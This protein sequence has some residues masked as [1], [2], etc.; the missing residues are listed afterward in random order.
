MPLYTL[1]L[2]VLDEEKQRDD[3]LLAAEELSE[4][5]RTLRLSRLLSAKE[6]LKTDRLSLKLVRNC[7]SIS[8]SVCY[9]TLIMSNSFSS[10]F[11]YSI[12]NIIKITH[13]TINHPKLHP[14][15][16]CPTI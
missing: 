6:A 12:T 3:A 2:E 13:N 9:F 5:E 11:A 8:S 4:Q 14:L 16:Y 15:T 7:P 10:Y 1:R